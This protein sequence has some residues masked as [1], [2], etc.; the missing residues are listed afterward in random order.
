HPKDQLAVLLGGW[1]SLATKAGVIFRRTP[2][3]WGNALRDVDCASDCGLDV[4]VH[5]YPESDLEKLLQ[6]SLATLDQHGFGRPKG[7]AVEGWVAS[8]AVLE[9]AA[10]VG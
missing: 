2:T 9:A 5:V 7:V 3:F 4:P 1:K 6:T 8:P 10:R